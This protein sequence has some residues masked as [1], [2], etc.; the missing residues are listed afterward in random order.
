[1]KSW[2]RLK[3]KLEVAMPLSIAIFAA[4]LAINDLFAGKYGSDE[5]KLSN[6]RN[7]SYQWYQSKGIKSTIVEGQVDLLQVLLASGSIAA[8]KNED[9][10]KLVGQLQGKVRKYEKEK[11]EILVGSRQL[12]QDLWVQPTDGKLGLIVGAKEYDGYLESLDSAGN[13]FDIA[14]MLFQLCLVTG[15]VGIMISRPTMKWNFFQVTVFAGIVGIFLS[16]SGIW[17]ATQV[18]M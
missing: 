7:N 11:T 3:S 12:P 5:I 13:F 17:T 1:M 2:V 14:S 9:M 6:M 4:V 10:Q 16:L 18:V 8:D 15:S